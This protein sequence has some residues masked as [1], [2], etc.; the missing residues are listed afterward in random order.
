MS[1]TVSFRASEELDE[2]LEDEA[3]R[4]MTTKSTVAQM[5][6]AER[7]KQIRGEPDAPPVDRQTSDDSP[8]EDESDDGDS[9]GE[10]FEKYPEKWYRPN[11]QN[12]NYAVYLKDK[13]KRKYYKTAEGAAKRLKREYEGTDGDK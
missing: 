1:K 12:Q 9:L 5:L 8:D 13:D 3:E 6:L 11:S 4:R 7:V 2:F 10:I